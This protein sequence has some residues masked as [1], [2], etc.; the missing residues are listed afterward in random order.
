[1]III[2]S[3]DRSITMQVLEVMLDTVPR[4]SALSLTCVGHVRTSKI[5]CVSL[6]AEVY[7]KYGKL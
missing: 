5:F 6:S 4:K 2:I 7:K 3:T 1:M